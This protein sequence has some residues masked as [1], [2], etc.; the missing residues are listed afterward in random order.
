M[1]QIKLKGRPAYPGKAVGEA[2]VCPHSIQGWAGVSETTGC[3][4]EKGH[5]EIGWSFPTGR[6]RRDGQATSIRRRLPVFL[7]RD[8]CFLRSIRAAV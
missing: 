2:I 6:A 4:I 7:R 8:G 5:P 1:K 3:I